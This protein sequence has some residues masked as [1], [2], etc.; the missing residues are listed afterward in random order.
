MIMSRGGR[1]TWVA[2]GLAG[3][4]LCL[5]FWWF[6]FCSHDTVLW[7]CHARHVLADGLAYTYRNFQEFNHPPLMG[8]CAAHAWS[9]ADGDVWRFVRWMK[10][11]GLAGEALSMWALWRFSGRP[12]FAVYAL[13]PAT[14]LVSGRDVRRRRSSVRCIGSSACR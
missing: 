10:L 14:I 5:L 3:V 7:S 6:S 9:W 13:C 4:V 12:A 1:W 2:A 8:L 11:P